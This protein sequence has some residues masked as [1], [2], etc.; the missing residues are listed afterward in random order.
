MCMPDEAPS[1]VIQAAGPSAGLP[2]SG[3]G[4]GAS[5][6][7]LAT[8]PV[9]HYLLSNLEAEVL[10]V[11]GPMVRLMRMRGAVVVGHDGWSCWRVMIE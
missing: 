4:M 2:G 9:G 11:N 3:A 7:F 6:P 5:P 10:A 8:T 1:T